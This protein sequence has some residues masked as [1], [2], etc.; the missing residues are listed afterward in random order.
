MG[1]EAGERLFEGM[2]EFEARWKPLLPPDAEIRDWEEAVGWVY[3]MYYWDFFAGLF[4]GELL[5]LRDG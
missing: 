2:G 3:L 1:G 4:S 5:L